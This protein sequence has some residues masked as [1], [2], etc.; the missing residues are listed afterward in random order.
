MTVMTET[1]DAPTAEA[2]QI[3]NLEYATVLVKDQAAALRFYTEMLGF[4]VSDD[5]T[6]GNGMRWLAVRPRGGQTKIVL[7]SDPDMQ[8]HG[9]EGSCCGSGGCGSCGIDYAWTGMVLSTPDIASSFDVLRERG[10]K[11]LQGPEEK[12]WGVIDAL[13][14]DPDGNV[15]NLV[16]KLD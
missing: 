8:A 5:T 16:Q 13:F 14:S 15:F 11:F 3:G 10:V 12:P 2:L 1:Y 9:E 4:E 7:Y 6:Y